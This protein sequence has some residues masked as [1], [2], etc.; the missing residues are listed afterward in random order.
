M[1]YLKLFE[2]SDWNWFFGSIIDNDTLE[3]HIR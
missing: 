3:D 1:K 2:E